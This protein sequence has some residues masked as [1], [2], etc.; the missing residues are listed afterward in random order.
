[1]RY[2]IRE[3]PPTGTF[4]P[5]NIL[6]FDLQ[7]ILNEFRAW[8]FP[9]I[10][11]M[12][13]RYT[14]TFTTGAVGGVPRTLPLAFAQNILI[15]DVG[16]QRVNLRGSSLHNL[17]KAEWG[18]SYHNLA[19]TAALAPATTQTMYI[20]VPILPPK[21]RRPRDYSLPVSTFLD[22]GVVQITVGAAEPFVGG[23]N[24]SAA[25]YRL[26][27]RIVEEGVPELKSRFLLRDQEIA[28]LDF[29]G[30]IVGG[31]LR[32]AWWYNGERNELAATGWPVQRLDSYT[33]NYQQVR[34]DALRHFHLMESETFRPDSGT[35]AAPSAI[36]QEDPVFTG[37]MVPLVWPGRTQKIT[38]MIQM[39]TLHVRTNLGAIT[40]TDL[41]KLIT[42]VLEERNPVA[43]QR[44]LRRTDVSAALKS[45][46]RVKT[47]NGN[48]KG[49]DQFPVDLVNV[50]PVKVDQGK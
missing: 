10:H 22:G 34:D 14:P 12:A 19:A 49:I 26:Q 18:L 3:V 33:L 28:L 25:D 8:S 7:S 5:G 21:A 27:L 42:T 6:T 23:Y 15:Q 32:S 29:P 4:S 31:F 45:N 20:P 37:Q 13:F 35:P 1:M 2:T 38:D 46:G 24:V 40:P 9:C 47:A 44:T 41:P 16:G 43:S 50:M 11:S 17:L 30:Y 36:Q 39:S 48:K